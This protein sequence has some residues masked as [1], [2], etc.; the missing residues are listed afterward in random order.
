[1][2]TMNRGPKRRN[3]RRKQRGSPFRPPTTAPEPKPVRG[4][5]LKTVSRF[6]LLFAL[7]CFGAFLAG[8]PPAAADGRAASSAQMGKSAKAARP[9][10]RN[11]D[12]R[13]VFF[14]LHR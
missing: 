7:L 3:Q 6:T 8:R 12:A 13:R 4:V 14:G 11:D 10:L 2:S 5:K 9:V 1:M